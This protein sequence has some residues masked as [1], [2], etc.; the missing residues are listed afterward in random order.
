MEAV[1]EDVKNNQN[2]TLRL[3]GRG[4]DGTHGRYQVINIKAGWAYFFNAKPCYAM[5][6][7]T[8][9]ALDWTVR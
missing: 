7:N 3:G 6:L 9:Q 5:P 8:M 1:T 4:M 2:Q